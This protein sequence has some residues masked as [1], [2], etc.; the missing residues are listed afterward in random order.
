MV[1]YTWSST[2][3][4]IQAPKNRLYFGH[5]DNKKSGYRVFVEKRKGPD[6]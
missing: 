4:I 2:F 6:D 5:E 1:V 3:M